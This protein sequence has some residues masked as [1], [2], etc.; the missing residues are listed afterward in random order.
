MSAPRANAHLLSVRSS[1]LGYLFWVCLL[2]THFGLS[3]AL[4]ETEEFDLNTKDVA[5]STLQ[6][7]SVTIT[8]TR[9]SS[10]QSPISGLTTVITREMIEARA[11][12]NIIDLLRGESGVHVAQSGG[13]GGVAS[14]QLRGGDPNFTLV[15]VDGIKVNDPTNARGGSFD[16]SALPLAQVERI[17][18]TRGAQSSVYGSDSLG[19]VI[20]ITTRESVD[21]G[22]MVDIVLGE[23]GFRRTS[24]SVSSSVTDI[25]QL[26]L[27]AS[28]EDDGDILVGNEFANDSLTG[29]YSLN[30]GDALSISVRGLLSSSESRA[31]PDDSGGPR[32]SVLRALGDR[33]KDQLAVSASARYQYTDQLE[34]NLLL[35]TNKHDEISSSPAVAPGV[36]DGVPASNIDSEFR[37]ENVAIHGALNWSE[38][39]QA[40]LGID[41][42]REDGELAGQIELFPGF[43]LPQDFALDRTT[44]GFFSEFAHRPSE[45]F[46]VN[47]SLRIDKADGFEE[48][49]TG[50]LGVEYQSGNARFF[51]SGGEGFKLPSFYALGHA[52]VGNA[53]LKPE[54]SRNV[55]A[56]VEWQRE[57]SEL[58]V[59]AFR[60]DYDN[61]IN[62]DPMIFR[63]V[64]ESDVRSEGMEFAARFKPTALA[65][66]AVNA[67]YVD[68]MIDGGGSLLQRPDWR[69][70]LNA[71][72][73]LAEGWSAT[74][75]WIYVG[76]LLDSAVPTGL[77]TV[78]AYN[79]LDMS[80]N[81]R[82]SASWRA[83]LAIDN[84]LNKSFETAIGFPGVGRRLRLGASYR[85]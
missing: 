60:S 46:G 3:S 16:F 33:E 81:W 36:R 62:F 8:G 40:I 68:V 12:E 71:Q 41:Y 27:T 30:D 69:F 26:S 37:R 13:R 14:V 42:L 18:I 9:I 25:S 72:W 21:L 76:D 78:A 48:R 38:N 17:E 24:I 19:G 15:L 85:F 61:L 55:E 45:Q 59:S 82:A 43:A 73:Q 83:F 65:S 80:V 5:A 10:D 44:T 29:S 28:S 34:L 64:N 74:A 58:S 54:T 11:D 32:L 47:V 77:E 20:S 49:I 53:D 52:L 79:R 2:M 63:L 75:D 67:T 66:I 31:F 6:I 7:E 22:G 4:A 39:T 84:A 50:R 56:G 23:S 51:V 1:S 57:K 35:G 70:G